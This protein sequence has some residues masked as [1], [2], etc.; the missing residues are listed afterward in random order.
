MFTVRVIVLVVTLAPLPVAAIEITVVPPATAVTTGFAPVAVTV[1]TAGLL[2]VLANVAV[3]APANV[4]VVVTVC[5]APGFC[6]VAVV[7]VTLKSVSAFGGTF[8]VTVAL[9]DLPSLV[10]VIVAVPGP[11]AVT[12]ADEPVPVT[13]AIPTLL[14]C[15]VTLRSVRVPPFDPLTTA[16]AMVDCPVSIV[17]VVSDTE[18]PVTVTLAVLSLLHPAISKLKAANTAHRIAG[19]IELSSPRIGIGSPNLL[20]RSA[21]RHELRDVGGVR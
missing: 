13:V 14:D 18:T 16:A 17:G 15:H 5:V 12:V 20:R 3:A 9:P 8:T 21:A 6:I 19:C 7:G 4:G 11:T 2:L 10:A 1:A